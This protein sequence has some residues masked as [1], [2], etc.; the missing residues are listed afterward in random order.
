M[1]PLKKHIFITAWIKLL[2][3]TANNSASA[4]MTDVN[5]MNSM[6]RG[7]LNGTLRAGV[8]MIGVGKPSP[9]QRL[10]FEHISTSSWRGNVSFPK[11]LATRNTLALW[12]ILET[13]SCSRPSCPKDL[14]LQI[15]G[16]IIAYMPVIISR[17]K[18]AVELTVGVN[19]A[20]PLRAPVPSVDSERGWPLRIWEGNRGVY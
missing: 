3:K 14:R 8:P 18:T 20:P 6:T 16:F 12:K 15:S 13:T 10:C 7:W 5:S 1:G 4:A 19:R 11:D 9:A 17:G 2:A